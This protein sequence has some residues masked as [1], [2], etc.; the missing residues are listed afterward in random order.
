MTSLVKQW[1]SVTSDPLLAFQILVKSFLLPF[2]V[3]PSLDS[4]WT[5][6]A[7]RRNRVSLYIRQQHCCSC[8]MLP[9]SVFNVCTPSFSAWVLEAD[10]LLRQAGVLPCYLDFWHFEIA[11]SYE[12]VTH[13]S[14]K[15]S[16]QLSWTQVSSKADPQ[17]S[18]LSSSFCTLEP[19]L[20]ISSLFS[21]PLHLWRH[22]RSP[23]CH[24]QLQEPY[25]P[26]HP[27]HKNSTLTYPAYTSW[28]SL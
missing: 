27:L 1:T 13:K 17:R 9:V 10:S 8:P 15:K 21:F 16:N 19:A 7:C 26:D 6:T 14:W 20:L 2:T 18:L 25:N 24:L 12:I 3:L 5:L 23:Q 28:R 22:K 4:N 11:C